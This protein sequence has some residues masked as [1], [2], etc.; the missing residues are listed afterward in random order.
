M[1][2]SVTYI[3]TATAIV[4]V[5][6]LRFLTDPIFDPVG[7]GFQVGMTGLIKSH[8][9]EGPALSAEEVGAIDAVLLSHDHHGDNLDPTGRTLLP[10]AGRVLTTPSGARRLAKELPDSAVGLRNWQSVVFDT[11]G[12]ETITVTAVPARHGPRF[13]RFLAGDV[14]GFIIESSSQDGAFYITG[15]TRLFSGLREI[16]AR[17][18]IGACLLHVGAARFWASGP[19]RYTMNAREAAAACKVLDPRIVLPIHYDGW[20]HFKEPK[21]EIQRAFQ[22]AGLDARLTWIPKGDTAVIEI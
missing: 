14:I 6:G 3:G 4:E 2:Y 12:G 10:Q 15:D 5:A 21:A 22:S 13:T 18:T 1:K 19:I 9:T 11:D 16:A 20:T 8:S 17:Y 7:S